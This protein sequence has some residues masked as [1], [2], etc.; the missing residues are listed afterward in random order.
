MLIRFTVENFLSFKDEVE[1]SMIPGKVRKHKNHILTNN[2]PNDIR[3]LKSGVIYGANASGKSNLIKAM[4]FAKTLIV[5][6]T[7]PKQTIPVMPF[8]FDSES[9]EK[10][11]RFQFELKH[12]NKSYIYGF[13]LNFKEIHTEWLYEIR[14]TTELLIFERA[15][16]GDGQ[17]KVEFDNTAINNKKDKDFLEFT[18]M[19]T[20]PNQLFLT[21]SMERNLPHFQDIYNWFDNTLVLLFA[22]TAIQSIALTF[23]GGETF[24]QQ[25]RNIIRLFDLGIDDIELIEQDFDDDTR[26]PEFIKTQL[27]QNILESQRGTPDQTILQFPQ[28]NILIRADKH[29]H[30][31]SLKFLTIHPIQHENRVARLELHQE[32]DGTQRLFEIMP[33]L[34]DLLNGQRNRVFVIDE[35]DRRLHVQLSRKIL[36]L[37]LNSQTNHNSQLIVTTHESSILDLDL[38]RRDEI[39]FIEKDNIGASSI[40]SLEEFAPRHDMDI[41]KGYL[42][43][44]FGAVPI[45]KSLDSILG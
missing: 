30:L 14:P 39:W 35:L 43:G 23:I 8:L 26:L 31:T 9:E 40:Y 25:F 11:S 12:Q 19:G 4:N 24:R 1:F 36:E 45:I 13:E 32:S 29:N 16:T 6:G 18:A 17:V 2:N 41:R 22:D 20:R 33:A 5:N 10:L 3:V 38:L 42:N 28:N 15:T 37:F 21:E 44:R 34:L 7:S 27:K